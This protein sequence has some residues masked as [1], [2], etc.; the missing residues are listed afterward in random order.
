MKKIL[1]VSPTPTHP[2]TAG[3]RTRIDGLLSGL[4]QLGHDV[5]FCHVQSEPGDEEAMRKVWGDRFFSVPYHRPHSPGARWKRKIQSIFKPDARYVYSID[6]WYDPS[7]DGAITDLNERFR[8]DVVIV[9]YVFFSRILELFGNDVL[10]IVDTHDVFTDRHLKYLKNGQV[11][12]WYSTTRQ[13][14]AKA[15]DRADVVIA[16]QDLERDFFSGLTSRKV[17]TIGHIVALR[18]ALKRDAG[19][20]ILFVAS[21][22]PINS[23]GINQFIADAFPAIRNEVPGAELALAGSVCKAVNDQP[24]VVKLGRVDDLVPVY[25]AA[26]VVIN[27]VRF[28]TGLSIKNLEA[29]GYSKPLV[30]SPT[31]AEGLEDGAG[32][33]F[34]LADSPGDFSEH[35][36][37]CLSDSDH[38]SR[39]ARG[40]YEY[41]SAWNRKTI[42]QLGDILA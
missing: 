18:E 23:D 40:A 26:A 34:L 42:R 28:N 37:K 6:E 4:Q 14:E 35:I 11:P 9:E 7:I 22:N 29:L 3:N 21:D 19:K 38:A 2:Q 1:L 15:L 17:I 33:A 20:Q 27:P 12:Q 41:A 36:I 16:I 32:S 10:K 39:L 25:E 8:F 5:Y 13:E 30:T 24:G 31:G